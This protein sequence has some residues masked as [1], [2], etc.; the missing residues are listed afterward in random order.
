MYEKTL[1]RA[2]LITASSE[3]MVVDLPTNLH[4]K[5]KILHNGVDTD[6]FNANINCPCPS[7]LLNIPHPR[8][9]NTGTIN[10]KIDL[11]LILKIAKKRPQWH[12]VLIGPVYQNEFNSNMLL[13]NAFLTCQQ[14]ENVHFLGEKSR[15]LIPSYIS[16][17]DV[18]TM[19]YRIKEDE[20]YFDGY[21]L[22]V[23]EYLAMG[24]P[25]ISSPI[26]A[27][28]THFADIV[29][30]ANGEAEWIAAI[31]NALTNGGVGTPEQRKALA[32]QNSWDNR[33]NVLEKWMFE[34][35]QNLS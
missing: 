9:V 27:I 20:W 26:N 16:H 15:F 32:I 5:I 23:N 3:S 22:K 35:I 11:P 21:P 7:D 4:T 8:I 18:T 6:L 2:D 34:F 10:R 24:K 30:I 12:W 1:A 29:D 13:S 14:L 33:V 25:T 19:N 17:A 28:K 31:D